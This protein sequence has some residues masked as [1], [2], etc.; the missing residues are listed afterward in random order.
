MDMTHDM[1]LQAVLRQWVGHQRRANTPVERSVGGVEKQ[2]SKQQLGHEQTLADTVGHIVEI[3]YGKSPAT[4]LA[5]HHEYQHDKVREFLENEDA[6]L[7]LHQ[8]MRGDDNG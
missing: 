5:K 6:Y 3:L 1:K 4:V 7:T 2:K 8:M